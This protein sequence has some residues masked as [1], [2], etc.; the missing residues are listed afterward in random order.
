MN[1]ELLEHA[2]L[3]KNFF[4]SVDAYLYMGTV[5]FNGHEQLTDLIE[6]K[7]NLKDIVY[8]L[9]VTLGGN[10]DAGFRISRALGHYYPK[11][12]K[13]FISDIC[14]SAGTLMAVGASELIISNKGELGPLDIQIQK[15]EEI[16]E[17]SSGLD[18]IQA[19]RILQDTAQ[20]AFKDYLIDLR[21]SG[22]GTKLAAHIAS[23]MATSLVAPI[24]S[25]I[26][27]AKLGEHQRAL[28]IA[29]VYG[30]RLN[31]KFKN[32]TPSGIDQLLVGYPTH[33]FVIDRKEATTLF[34]RVRAPNTEECQLEDL[35]RLTVPRLKESAS[36]SNSS[37]LDLGSLIC[38]ILEVE[39]GA[40]EEISNASSGGCTNER[41]EEIV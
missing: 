5:D 2:K 28:R 1:T 25:Q 33:G 4:D 15:K 34:K 27:P 8:F 32:T 38:S 29:A 36:H 9:P 6:K 7:E 19:L 40:N 3:L 35:I 13:C 16:F 26:D 17:M 14:K 37:V 23:E 41:E 22:L 24:A 18:I 11:G 31:E 12:V 10:P 21:V 20:N 39:N 30:S